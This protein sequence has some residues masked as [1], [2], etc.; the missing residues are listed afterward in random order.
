M[1]ALAAPGPVVF[2]HPQYDLIDGDK[3]QRKK[4]APPPT[5]RAEHIQ[6]EESVLAELLRFITGS[7]L[8]SG[9][10]EVWIP[11]EEAPAKC[12]VYMTSEW[13]K[14][15][16]LLVVIINQVSTED[17][18][19]LG[20]PSTAGQPL[21]INHCQQNTLQGRANVG[22]LPLITPVWC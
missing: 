18:Y 11:D 8:A 1:A 16:R 14:A 19:H 10:N 2:S 21:Q 20:I 4:D 13:E 5:N 7:M 9:F 12:P 22:D 3:I 15:P 6:E 17:E